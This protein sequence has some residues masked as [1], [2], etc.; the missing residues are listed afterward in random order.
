MTPLLRLADVDAY[1]GTAQALFHVDL[2]VPPGSVVAL[3]GRNGAGKTTTL[4][5][6]MRL[7]VT[8]YGSIAFDGADLT[9]LSTSGVARLGIGYVPEDRRIYARMTVLENLQLGRGLA[10]RERPELGMSVILDTFPLLRP[11]LGRRGGVLSG[12]EQQLLAAARSLIGNPR[13]MLLDEPSEG[14]APKIVTELRDAIRTLRDRFRCTVLLAE[15]NTR[16]ALSLADRA[17]IV[18]TGRI[19]WNGTVEELERAPEVLERSLGVS[20]GPRAG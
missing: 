17:A 6:V 19:V 5:S 10:H 13:L 18:E 7:G 12:G 1:Y 15:Q 14:L 9:R 11:L 8:T 16:F 20:R 2:E 3:L 4:R